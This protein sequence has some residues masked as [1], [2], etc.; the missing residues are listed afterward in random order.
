MFFELYQSKEL[1]LREKRQLNEHYLYFIL[2][3]LSIQFL[4]L[5]TEDTL[6]NENM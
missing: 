4:I 2:L 3:R 5:G 6:L 1:N